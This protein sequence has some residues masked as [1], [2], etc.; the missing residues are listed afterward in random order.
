MIQ[1]D[2]AG[3]GSL[4]GG[5]VIGIIRTETL[6]FYYDI[7]PVE[8]FKTP[9]F[10]EKKYKDYCIKIIEEG[11]NE[12][13]VSKDEEIE[14]CQGYIFDKARNYLKEK[15]YKVLSV[16]ISEPLQSI[17]EET[18]IDYAIG[19]GIPLDYLQY[20]KYPFHFHRLL[21]WVL[22]DFKKRSEICKTGWSSYKKYSSIKTE[23]YIDYLYNSNFRCL[24]CGDIIDAP[25][26]VSVIKF[27]TNNEYFIYLHENCYSSQ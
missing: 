15:G 12:L 26:K 27:V 25:C 11:L 14:I 17:I 2:D 8:F 9:E 1:I 4:V 20:T 16:K 19:L 10:E 13:K 6:D 23:H 18:F 21:K 3:S 5:T 24:K 7:I 22:A